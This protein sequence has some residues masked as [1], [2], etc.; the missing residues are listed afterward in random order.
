[1]CSVYA[2]IKDPNYGLL[3]EARLFAVDADGSNARELSTRQNIYSPSL[4]MSSAQV[5]DWSPCDVDAVLMTRAYASGDHGSTFEGSRR[6]LGLDCVNTRTLEAKRV[7]AADPSI[8][9]Y[10]TDGRGALRIMA[11]RIKVGG[12]W[13]DSGK[14]RYVYRKVGSHDWQT[15]DFYD[16][17]THTGFEPAVVDPDLD[18]AYGFLKKD[19]RVAAYTMKLDGTM[20]QELV[21]ARSDVDVRGL[22]VFGRQ[23]RVVGVSYATDIP[24]VYYFAPDIKL[25]CESLAAT[26]PR[27]PLVH[28]LDASADGH[29]LLIFASSDNDPGTYYVLDRETHQLVSF[30]AVRDQL[31]GVR[32]AHVKAV[33]YP[34]ADGTHIPAYLT[35]PAG[36]ED[37]KGLPAI[38]MPHGGPSYRDVWGFDWLPQYFA[39][40]GYAVLQ[41]EFR[42]SS[43]FGD[44][45]FV[46][47]GFKSWQLAIGDV[48]AGGRWLVSEGIADPAKLGIVGWSYGG[49][50]ALQSVTLDMNPFKAVVAIAPVTDLG[51][52]RDE[53]LHWSDYFIIDKFLGSGSA[54]REA[55]P[56]QRAD[57][58]KVPVLLV[59]GTLDFNV[60]VDESRAMAKKLKS[61]G[62]NVELMEFEGLDHQL[63]DSQARAEFLRRADQVLSKAFNP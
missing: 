10:I 50:A 45:W 29:H 39:A 21:Y 47:N 30:S 61:L 52:L 9:G 13:I 60:A 32:L 51:M 34:A 48:I 8:A 31:E 49:Y 37:A 33:D 55:S 62:A 41:P 43:G 27:Q 24:H 1:V 38:V 44:D 4:G 3:P 11:L 42:G 54:S 59:H 5:I 2:M 12:G 18:V 58:I 20:K 7:N 28:V 22:V 17:E 14:L 23:H 25:L 16:Y 63:G 15:L 53:H 56:L 35:L 57:K 6:G 26:L 46:N 36:H 19:G 40:R